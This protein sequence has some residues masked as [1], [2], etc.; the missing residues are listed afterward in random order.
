MGDSSNKVLFI[1][2]G[3]VCVLL[4]C[5]FGFAIVNSSLSRGNDLNNQMGAKVDSMLETQYT[6]FQGTT[7]SGSQVLNFINET[8]NS[9]DNVYVQ[10]TTTAGGTVTYVCDATSLAKFT[11]TAQSTLVQNAKNKTNNAYIFPTGNFSG[12]IQRNANGAIIGVQF[13]QV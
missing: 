6:Q 5:G 4:V 12:A 3:I 9:Q 13:T 11:A 7:V 2:A 8:F 1:I 10:V